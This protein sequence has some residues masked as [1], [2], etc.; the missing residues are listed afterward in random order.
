MHTP[1]QCNKFGLFFQHLQPTMDS[2][3]SVQI[4][5][6][7]AQSNAQEQL[8]Y[9][10]TAKLFKV[11]RTTL[12][13]RHTLPTI[14]GAS[15]EM[16]NASARHRSTPYATSQARKSTNSTPK[17]SGSSTSRKVI[18][19][20]LIKVMPPTLPPLTTGQAG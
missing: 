10:A 2:S 4:E 11:D 13:R 14:L 17:S 9:A 3:K 12:W 19:A 7:I 8:N 5:R 16:W 18:L 15:S 1:T 20:S 6:A